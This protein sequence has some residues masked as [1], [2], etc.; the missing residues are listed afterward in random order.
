MGATDTDPQGLGAVLKKHR[1]TVKMKQADLA[2]AAGCQAGMISMI[3]NGERKPSDELLSKLADALGTT[4]TSLRDEARPQ[5]LGPDGRLNDRDSRETEKR[6]HWQPT[7]LQAARIA[8]LN[9]ERVDR[10]NQEAAALQEQATSTI[11]TLIA[12][13]EVVLVEFLEPAAA[14]VSRVYGIPRETGITLGSVV[15]GDKSTNPKFREDEIAARDRLRKSVVGVVG[16]SAAGA[17]LGA[18]AGGAAAAALYGAA[19]MWATS[20]TGTAIAGLSGAA[21]TSATFAWLGGGSLAAGGLGIAGGTAVLTGVIAAPVLLAAGVAASVKGRSLRKQAQAE[22]EALNKIEQDFDDQRKHVM[23]WLNWAQR[24]TTILLIASLRG[25]P[26]MRLVDPMTSIAT[27]ETAYDYDHLED[28]QRK[29]LNRMID[30]MTVVLRVLGLPILPETRDEVFYPVDF[31][32]QI[33]AALTGAL[34]VVA[35]PDE[36]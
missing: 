20:S 29:H 6:S 19:A 5:A 36:S 35:A 1:D 25:A 14:L 27:S 33:E 9:K 32:K 26:L 16:A 3:E 15:T 2:L 21:A 8:K 34:D 18:A 28:S 17:G 10:L 12:Q 23:T 7:A 30:L 11:N 4:P 31:V 22:S 24:A 13:R